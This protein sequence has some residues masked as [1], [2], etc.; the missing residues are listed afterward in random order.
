M[1]FLDFVSVIRVGDVSIIPIIV[2]VGR[3]VHIHRVV[4]VFRTRTALHRRRHAFNLF[5]VYGRHVLAQMR[6]GFMYRT[7]VRTDKSVVRL[8]RVQGEG[9]GVAKYLSAFLAREDGG[10]VRL[11]D[12]FVQVRAADEGLAADRAGEPV[13]R[14]ALADVRRLRVDVLEHLA[15]VRALQVGVRRAPVSQK[16]VAALELR[17]AEMARKPA[18]LVVGAD[19]PAEIRRRRE[20]LPANATA[21]RLVRRVSLPLCHLTS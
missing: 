6:G 12:V 1:I 18:G 11:P 9:V 5:A 15:A 17:R 13:R 19:V 4:A 20:T 8:P 10:A 7:A 14:P 16:R 3:V 2:A 21:V